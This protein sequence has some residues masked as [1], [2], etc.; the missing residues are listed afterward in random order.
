MVTG[1]YF[2]YQFVVS[3]FVNINVFKSGYLYINWFIGGL[4]CGDFGLFYFYLFF[5]CLE[6]D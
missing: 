1:D 3:V 4:E 6:G 5:L 2:E